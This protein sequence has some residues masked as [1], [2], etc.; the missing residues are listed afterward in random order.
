MAMALAICARQPE[1]LN[2]YKYD[3]L[4]IIG[5]KLIPYD[6]S[7][8][9]FQNSLYLNANNADMYQALTLVME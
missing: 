4:F 2:I 6:A 9:A 8:H 5:R 1:L 3:H 7:Y